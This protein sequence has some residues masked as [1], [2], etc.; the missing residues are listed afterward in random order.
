MKKTMIGI[1]GLVLAIPMMAPVHAATGTQEA[2]TSVYY[3]KVTEYTLSIPDSIQVDN[4]NEL[5]QAIGVSK[6]NTRHNEKVQIKVKSGVDAN[7][8]ILRV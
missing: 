8:K 6:K 4:I 3:D 2:T 5:E 7:G 1:V